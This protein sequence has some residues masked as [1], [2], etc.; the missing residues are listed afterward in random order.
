M[1]WFLCS[2]VYEIVWN[3]F[4]HIFPFCYHQGMYKNVAQN[5]DISKNGKIREIRDVVINT[6][7]LKKTSKINAGLE[8]M[9]KSSFD[10]HINFVILT[11]IAWQSFPVMGS[12]CC[13]EPTVKIWHSITGFP[14]SYRWKCNAGW[15]TDFLIYF[16]TY[17]LS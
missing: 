14:V 7:C 8:K 4:K 16:V 3:I 12:L 9:E 17:L 6:F 13:W 10:I 15:K 1:L 2:S 5:V 11:Y